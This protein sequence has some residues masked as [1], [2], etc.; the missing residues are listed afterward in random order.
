MA[1]KFAHYFGMCATIV[2]VKPVCAQV[3]SGHCELIALL[4]GKKE[5]NT[6]RD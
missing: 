6:E 5:K 2:M 1:T 3:L 4:E